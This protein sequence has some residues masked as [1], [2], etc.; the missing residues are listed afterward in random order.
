MRRI[1]SDQWPLIAAVLVLLISG[2]ALLFYVLFQKPPAGGPGPPPAAGPAEAPVKSL[3]ALAPDPRWDQLARFADTQS[4]ADFR[5]QMERQIAAVCNPGNRVGA[6]MAP[7]FKCRN[8]LASSLE[9]GIQQLAARAA[10][11]RYAR[12]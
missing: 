4:V 6:D 1:Q 12:F 3:S 5:R 11:N 8:E 7:D 9:P 10:Q 2:G